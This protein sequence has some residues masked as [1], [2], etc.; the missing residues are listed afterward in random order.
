MLQYVGN[1]IVNKN[2]KIEI[3]KIE[4]AV[5]EIIEY[6]NRNNRSNKKKIK[7]KNLN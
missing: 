5:T 4:I 6:D 2:R 1:H 7:Q 3:E